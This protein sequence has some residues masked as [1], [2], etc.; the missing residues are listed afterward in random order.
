MRKDKRLNTKVKKNALFRTLSMIAGKPSK[1]PQDSTFLAPGVNFGCFLKVTFVKKKYSYHGRNI[2]KF[3]K[4]MGWSLVI[5]CE[6]LYLIHFFEISFYFIGDT[7]YSD[8]ETGLRS[9]F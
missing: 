1:G 4:V 7:L 9:I 8:P 3:I 5:L 2:L 6:I